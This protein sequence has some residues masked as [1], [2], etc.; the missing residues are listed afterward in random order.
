[1]Y[2]FPLQSPNT[3]PQNKLPPGLGGE[4]GSEIS[5]PESPG[6]TKEKKSKGANGIATNGGAIAVPGEGNPD[7][8]PKETEDFC[9][10][11][12]DIYSYDD[13]NEIIYCDGCNVAVHQACYG[14]SKIPAGEWLCDRCKSKVLPECFLCSQKGGAMKELVDLP[15]RWVHV[16]C[17]ATLY[18]L[19]PLDYSHKIGPPGIVDKIDKRR[20]HLKCATCKERNAKNIT[21]P[22]IQC[23]SKRCTQAFHP[24]CCKKK[25]IYCKDL[26]IFVTY[27]QKHANEAPQTS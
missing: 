1:M 3:T 18:E 15:G 21:G 10:V 25:L 24:I 20:Y 27:C 26:G 9:S 22:L 16:T 17:V 13:N 7:E 11:C 23:K 5:Q 6:Q 8:Y 12:G 2:A 14:V 4:P 19:R